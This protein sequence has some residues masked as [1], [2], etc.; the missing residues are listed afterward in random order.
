MRLILTCTA[1]AALVYLLLPIFAM[2]SA[3]VR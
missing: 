3:V 1:I 2:L